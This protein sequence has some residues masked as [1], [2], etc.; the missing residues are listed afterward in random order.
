MTTNKYIKNVKQNNWP[1]FNKKL[2]QRNYYEHVIRNDIDLYE[3][4]EYINNN[5][6]K[7]HLD[8]Y[9]PEIPENKEIQYV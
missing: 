6:K 7:W 8:K 4:R 9:N 2:W 1:P 3:T 5:Q